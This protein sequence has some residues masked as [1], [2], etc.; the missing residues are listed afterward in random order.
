ML[1]LVLAPSVSAAQAPTGRLP[2]PP[3]PGGGATTSDAPAP[4][5]P[6]EGGAEQPKAAPS[7]SAAGYA[8]SDKPT[9]KRARLVRKASGPI[10]TLPGFEQTADGGSRL[11]VALSQQVQVEERK[12]QGSITYVLKGARIRRWNN[13]NALVT[14]HFNTPVYRAKLVPRGSDLHFVVE[15]RAAAAP[16]WKMQEAQDKSA[17]LVIE[18][19]K[20]DYVNVEAPPQEPAKGKKK[21]GAAPPPAPAEEPQDNGA[22]PQP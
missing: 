3:P 2:P 20:G 13:T 18:F 10:A 16:T 6:A 19:G 21:K 14:V 4:A 12:A 9:R 17:M 7:T 15:L 5:Q 1:A 8:Y 22:G 11:F